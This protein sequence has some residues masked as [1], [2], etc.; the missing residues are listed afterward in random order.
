VPPPIAAPSIST[1]GMTKAEAEVMK[2]SSAAFASS[3]VKGRSSTSI[4]ASR[5]KRSTAARVIP[6]RI[7][8]PRCRVMILPPLTI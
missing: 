5:A 1:T 8:V 4:C 6:C 2:A 3:M 7:S